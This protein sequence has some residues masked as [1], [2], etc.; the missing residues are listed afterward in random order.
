MFNL[1]LGVVA[2]QSIAEGEK[3]NELTVLKAN[4]LSTAATGVC[5][6]YECHAQ[7]LETTFNTNNLKQ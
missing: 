2:C 1:G 6:V 7:S 5:V 4:F 3:K